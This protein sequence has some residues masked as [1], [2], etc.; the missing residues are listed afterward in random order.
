M[1]ENKDWGIS[2][3]KFFTCQC[4]SIQFQIC[5]KFIMCSKCLRKY[6]QKELMIMLAGKEG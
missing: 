3:V 1:G 2:D 5:D 4:G 6:N